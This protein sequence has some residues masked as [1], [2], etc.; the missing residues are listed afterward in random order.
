LAGAPED[1]A[2]AYKAHLYKKNEVVRLKKDSRVFEAIVKEVN[3]KG[4]LVVQH[5]IEENFEVGEV[6]WII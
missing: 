1:V 2:A 5:S 6:E 3:N 4:Q